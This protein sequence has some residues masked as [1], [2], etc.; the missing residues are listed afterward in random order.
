MST[1]GLSSPPPLGD[2]TQSMAFTHL[3]DLKRGSRITG[4]EYEIYKTHYTTMHNRVIETREKEAGL[5]KLVSILCWSFHLQFTSSITPLPLVSNVCFQA[6][7]L[8]INLF[9]IFFSFVENKM[10]YLEKRLN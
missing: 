6:I 5:I 9:I 3:E 7:S 8:I 2:V 10:M 4:A 1:D